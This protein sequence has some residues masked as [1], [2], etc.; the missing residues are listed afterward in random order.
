MAG[1]AIHTLYAILD[2]CT[3]SSYFVPHCYLIQRI[4]PSI[5]F[6]VHRHHHRR[7]VIRPIQAAI[8]SSTASV[9][10]YPWFGM[11]KPQ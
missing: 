9:R 4:H 8:A 11:R 10:L 3:S 2:R 7:P 5:I 1:H 6:R